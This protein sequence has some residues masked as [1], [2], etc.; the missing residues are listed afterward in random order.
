MRFA[1]SRRCRSSRAVLATLACALGEARAGPSGGG[2][3]LDEKATGA[4]EPAWTKTSR[5][6]GGHADSEAETAVPMDTCSSSDD[7]EWEDDAFS[8]CCANVTAWSSAQRLLEVCDP[9]VWVLQETKH[10]GADGVLTAEG[11]AAHR[12]WKLAAGAGLPGK[13]AARAGADVATK[14]YYTQACWPGCDSTTLWPGRCTGIHVSGLARGGIAVAS[15]YAVVGLGM[16]GEN[17]DMLDLLEEKILGLNCLWIVGGDFNMKPE[18]LRG[19]AMRTGGIVVAPEGVT[20]DAGKGSTIDFTWC[21]R[22]SSTWSRSG[23]SRTA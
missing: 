20:C 17:L 3:T 13:K 12:G 1:Q 16:K 15:L 2:L 11:W 10:A 14:S 18:E 8:V 23:S 6:E 7:E 9:D 21:I 22:R 4:R 19:F 5:A